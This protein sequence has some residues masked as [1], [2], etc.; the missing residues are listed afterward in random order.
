VLLRGHLCISGN[1]QATLLTVGEPSDVEIYG[2]KLVDEIGA[3]GA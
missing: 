1:V 2:Q 3:D